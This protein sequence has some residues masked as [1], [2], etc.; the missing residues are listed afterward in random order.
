MLDFAIA[1]FGREVFSIF[2]R[3]QPSLPDE[4]ES[5]VDNNG[6]DFEVDSEDYAVEKLRFG[7]C[8]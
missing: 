7:F 6:G 1:L 4:P 3:R 2:L 8:R 5:H